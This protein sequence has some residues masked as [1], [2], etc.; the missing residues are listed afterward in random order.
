MRAT[1]YFSLSIVASNIIRNVSFNITF[2]CN[3][4]NQRTIEIGNEHIVGITIRFP[5]WNTL[6]IVTYVV[7]HKTSS[8]MVIQCIANE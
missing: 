3:K 6:N 4:R 7:F 8:I 1:C 2:N 5:A